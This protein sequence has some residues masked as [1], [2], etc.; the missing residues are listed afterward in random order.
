MGRKFVISFLFILTSV[1][2]TV[3]SDYDWNDC[4]GSAKP[5][6]APSH[7]A[8]YPDS[9]TPVMINHVGRHGAR[10]PASPK[11]C[12]RLR[13]ALKAAQEQA[14]ITPTGIEL[15]KLV[16]K[17]IDKV[18]GQW[19]A[20][21]S[22]GMAEQQGIAGRMIAA[23]PELFRN[24]AVNAIS[25]YSPRCIMSMDEFTHLLARTDNTVELTL[26]SGQRFS[27][28]LRFFDN[29]TAYTRFRHSKELKEAYD[30]FIKSTCPTVQLSLILGTG[31]DF[32]AADMS[33]HDVALAEYAVLSGLEAMG[34]HADVNRYLTPQE[35]NALWS[36]SNMRHYLEHSSSNL[37]E[38]PSAIAA[39]LL[40]N[41]IETTDAVVAGE[42]YA[43]R[44]MLRFG[45]AE[46]LMPLLALMRIP[47]CYY[48][49][50]NLGSV[51]SHWCDFHVVP[52]AANLQLILFRSRSGAF[53]V[54]ADLNEVP[55]RLI[56]ERNQT[57]IPWSEA[58][59]YLSDLIQ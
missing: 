53:Y 23:Y 59:V 55:V 48:L 2:L 30:G 44:V 29:N 51:S 32:S 45:H 8:A 18:G 38:I 11:N 40:R 1:T 13:S 39:P 43:P 24:S 31:F 19:G 49:T 12:D 3:A 7:A 27:P 25:S 41:L 50:D 22:L 21:D 6:P 17:V 28:L 57:Y 47:E 4:Q 5:Y 42:K 26:E 56:A 37:S 58:R 35:Q 54:R 33:K 10:F 15:L 36:I 14:T 20:L 34:I 52:M 9:L 16:D 46:T